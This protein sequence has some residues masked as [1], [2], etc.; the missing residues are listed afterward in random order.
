MARA[1]FR[2]RG[3]ALEARFR[4]GLVARHPRGHRRQVQFRGGLFG[5]TWS[6]SLPIFEVIDFGA[7]FYPP[8]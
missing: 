3:R 8:G 1:S 6:V 4:T 5:T 2:K 7:G